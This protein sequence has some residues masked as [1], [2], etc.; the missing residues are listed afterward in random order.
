[1]RS[2]TKAR[3][4]DARLGDIARATSD[5]VQERELADALDESLAA[6]AREQ[7]DSAKARLLALRSRS[8]QPRPREYRRDHD[9]HLQLSEGGAETAP[10]APAKRDPGVGLGCVLEEAL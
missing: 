8:S 10:H 5:A 9:L 4:G 3:F 7:R 1:M 6:T 2:A